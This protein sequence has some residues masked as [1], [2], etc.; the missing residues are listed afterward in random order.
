MDAK[1]T[2]HHLQNEVPQRTLIDGARDFHPRTALNIIFKR[3]T[4]PLGGTRN[5][6]RC[7]ALHAKSDA[8]LLQ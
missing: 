5:C 6:T 1:Q 8:Y 7:G 4:P 2:R 3:G